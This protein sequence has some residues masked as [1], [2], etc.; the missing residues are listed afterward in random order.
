MF[1]WMLWFYF[2]LSSRAINV[3]GYQI[4]CLLFVIF[5]IGMSYMSGKEGGLTVYLIVLEAHASTAL[6]TDRWLGNLNESTITWNIN[7]NLNLENDWS[8]YTV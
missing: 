4:H 1:G 6:P 7:R 2:I 5:Q 3:C 8:Y